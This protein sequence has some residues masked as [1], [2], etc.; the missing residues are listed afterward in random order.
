MTVG[1]KLTVRP[2]LDK[3]ALREQCRAFV[4]FFQDEADDADEV[5]WQDVEDFV[6]NVRELLDALDEEAADGP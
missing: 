4:R 3:L 6:D 1:G 2:A 5:D